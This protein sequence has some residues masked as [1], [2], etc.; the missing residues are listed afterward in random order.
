MNRPTTIALVL[1]LGATLPATAFAADAKDKPAAATKLKKNQAWVAPDWEARA[2]KAIAI[3][4]LRSIERNPE[5]EA[6]GKRGLETA[7]AGQPYRF[8]SSTTIA[9][10]IRAAKADAAWSAGFTAAAKGAPLD[11]ASARALREALSSDA[12]LFSSV[13]GWQRYVVDEQTRGASFTQVGVD[14][15]MYGLTDGTVVWR[16]SFVEKL[17]GPYNEPQT[18]PSTS[19]DPSG[20]SGRKTALEPPSYDEA[21]LKVMTR[22]A[23]SLPRPSAP[24]APAKS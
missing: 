6:L 11:T 24:A 4:P 12:I 9:E 1:L 20:Y 13:T 10:A 15:V 14:A 19:R 17:D 18:D 8:R 22:L 3:A 2:I 5:A 16:G 23:G 21:V 7:L